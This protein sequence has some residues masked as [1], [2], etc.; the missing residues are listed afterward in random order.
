MARDLR[1]PVLLVLLA[2]IDIGATPAVT[3]RLGIATVT[4]DHSSERTVVTGTGFESEDIARLDLVHGAFVSTEDFGPRLRN[5]RVIGRKLVVEVHGQ[6]VE[7]ETEGFTDTSRM[8]PLPPE[9]NLVAAFVADFRVRPILAKWRIGWAEERAAARPPVR[10]FGTSNSVLAFGTDPVDCGGAAVCPTRWG[11]T[12]VCPL[13]AATDALVVRSVTADED[14]V[15]S[16]CTPSPTVPGL[17]ALKVCAGGPVTSCGFTSGGCKACPGFPIFST[18]SCSLSA[19]DTGERDGSGAAIFG[20]HHCDA[21]PGTPPTLA[22]GPDLELWPPNRK[23]FA[24]TLADFVSAIDACDGALDVDAAGT[25]LSITSNESGDGSFE[26]TG[27]SSFAVRA[28]RNGDA[29]ARLY[30]IRFVVTDE[31]GAAAEGSFHI[32]VPRS[33]TTSD[34]TR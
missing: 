28:E 16:C 4:I 32:R 13:S 30:E 8:P 20:V 33:K 1:L 14:I 18:S 17:L 9:L 27:P 2:S 24:F 10:R 21:A 23:M 3:P 11:P 12:S 22:I 25:I 7:W 29:I 15:A 19:R 6:R 31:F 5:R 34:S 26:I